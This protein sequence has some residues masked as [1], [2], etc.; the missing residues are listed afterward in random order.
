L[1]LRVGTT[2]AGAAAFAAAAW[3]V[4]VPGQASLALLVVAGA[5]IAAGALWLETSAESAKELALVATIA[6][7]AA[8]GRVLF[9]PVPGV[10]PLT[11]MVVATGVALGAR[12]GILAG[13]VAAI[14]SDLFLGIGPWTPW[15]VLAWGACGAVGAVARPLLRRRIP[16][17][18][19]CFVLGYAFS[20]LMDGW[21]WFS[22]WPHTWQALT[23]VYARGFPFETSHAV[24]NLILALV[25]GPELRRLLERYARRLHTEVVW[26]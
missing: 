10:Q 24:G 15:Y 21:E 16:F 14:V 2:A 22:F 19:A 12:S 20:A 1:Q 23:V 5:L 9:A 3:T 26:E 8:A 6:G 11:V 7:A 18:F 17:A 25:A 13:G 4:E